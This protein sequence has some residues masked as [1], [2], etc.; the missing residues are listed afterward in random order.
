MIIS[1]I[2]SDSFPHLRDHYE[3]ANDQL[4]VGLIDQLVRALHR[5]RRGRG[6][7][8]RSSL[9]F[10]RFF[11]YKTAQVGIFYCEGHHHFLIFDLVHLL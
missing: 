6:L 7:E 3:F 8:S 10:F 4:P 9:N 5:Y 2:H 1:H 11:F